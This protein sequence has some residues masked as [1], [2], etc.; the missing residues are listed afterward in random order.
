MNVNDGKS[1][2]T[3]SDRIIVYVSFDRFPSSKGA[4]THIDAFIRALGGSFGNVSLITI[5][6]VVEEVES[7]VPAEPKTPKT[8]TTAGPEDVNPYLFAPGVMHHPLPA[9]GGNL[10]ERVLNYR[11]RMLHWWRYN[12]PTDRKPDVVHV[13]SIYEGYPIACRK[14]EFCR[15]F[16]FE[17]NG[18]PSIELKYHYPN[19]A[20]DRELLAKLRHQEETCLRAADLIITVSH[21]NAEHLRQRGA[22]PTRIRV[23]PNGVD[24]ERFTFQPPRPWDDREVNLL[25]AG[26]MASWQ[27]VYSAIEAL[28]LY[29]RD[30]PARLKLVGLVRLW[31]RKQL[32]N[33]AYELGVLPNIEFCNSVDKATLL[34][35]HHQADV[36]LAPLTSNDRNCDQGCCPLKVLEAMASGTPLIAS[37]LPVV[38]ELTSDLETM[39]VKPGSGKAIKDAMLRLRQ[40]HVLAGNLSRFARKRVEQD[41][42]W[43]RA[44]T[45]LVDAYEELFADNRSN[46]IRKASPSRSA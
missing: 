42:G 27:G 36:V 34:E 1:T 14:S 3:E 29:R 10:F 35:L 21:V 24:L 40:D 8:A 16:V 31:Q 18:L 15:H 9:I 25:Y 33:R 38:R 44:Q 12:L 26:T 2:Q 41:F 32:T 20:D 45:A 22:D 13:R 28:A 23:I 5:P 7:R 6:P 4:A 17:V 11:T 30:F 46:T 37:D 19:V 39:L 43:T